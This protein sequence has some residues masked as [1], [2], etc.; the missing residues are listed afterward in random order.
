MHYTRSGEID[1]ARN[2]C[3]ICSF[4]PSLQPAI[5]PCGAHYD[6]VNERRHQ[7]GV[8]HISP[9]PASFGNPTTDD[10]CGGSTEGPLKEPHVHVGG[11]I[12]VWV[13]GSLGPGFG[14]V[15]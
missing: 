10:R 2:G 14:S 11:A 15:V 4:H 5:A 12:L 13:D 6:W 3:T 7:E 1:I 9:H 8:D